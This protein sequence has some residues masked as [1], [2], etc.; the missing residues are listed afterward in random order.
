M[1]LGR[2]RERSLLEG[3]MSGARV[4]QSAV[5]VLTGEV[6]IGKSTLLEDAAA[7]ATGMRLLR[8]TGTESEAEVPFGA[9]LQLLRPALVQLDRIPAPQAEALATALALRPGTGSD[10]FAVGAGTLSLLSRFAEDQPLAVLVDDAHLLDQPSAQALVFAARRLTADPVVLLAAVRDGEPSPLLDAGLP[11]LAVGGLSPAASEDLVSASGRRLGSPVAARLYE[12]TGG[13]PLALLELADDAA[14]VDALPPGAPVPVPARVARAFARRADRLSAPARTA[15]LVA[16]AAGDDLA[17]IARACRL[18]DV[19]A[20]TLD[21]AET[22]QLLTVTAGRVGFRHNLVRSAV[23]SE[24]PPGVRR[25][26]HRALAAALPEDDVDH[27]AWHLGEAALGPDEDTARVLDAAA[28]RARDRSAHAVAATAFERAARLSPDPG[29]AV[30][31][32]VSAAESAWRAG[33]ADQAA[34]LLARASELPQPPALCVRAT[35]L[36]G[37][38]ASRTGSVERARDELMAAAAE[39]AGA[40]PDTAILLLA[41]AILACFFLADTATV[42]Q[43]AKRIDRL[44]DRAVGEPARW[45]GAVAGGVAGVLTGHGGPD[46]IRRAVRLLEP[47]APLLR[48]PRLAPWLVLGVLFL[49]ERGTG[50][51]IVAAVVDDLRRRSDLGGLPYLLFLVAR[52]QATGDRWDVA[53][54]NYTEG[55]QLARETGSTSD[56]AACLAGLAWLQARQG[57]E[58]ACRAHATEALDISGPRHLALFQVWSLSALGSLELGLGRPEAALAHLR[59]LD[60]LLADLRLVDVD[61]SPAPELAEALVHLGRAEDAR[62]QVARYAARA[63]EKGQPWALARAARTVALTCEDTDIDREFEQALEHHGRTLDPF[64]LARTQLAYGARL[65]RARRRVDAR[66][67]LRAALTAFDALGAGPWGDRAAVELRA[68]GGSAQRRQVSSVSDLTPQELQIAT[69]LAGGRTTREAAAALFLSPKTVE[70]HLRHVYLK[71][72]VSSRA[73][74]AVRLP[75]RG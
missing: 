6:G 65:R 14:V 44:V 48:D 70:Y 47:G 15:L 10:R 22:A 18:L 30:H 41:D 24:A 52:D 61:L 50:R 8:A 72:G 73:E 40:D 11:V 49:R 21:E 67:Q 28:G 2:E 17:L 35:G 4:G 5:L 19:D 53:E 71:L 43:A 33:L 1:L 57:R 25:A 60:A 62:A 38:I 54:V 3:L 34:A 46:R 75:A 55:A 64:E 69:M 63:A 51:E 42:A 29:D 7:S 12:A 66:V 20:A 26:V 59:R 32:L 31:R 36:G 39:G 9:L 56:L 16:A 58:D 23:W 45:V 68:T 74:L 27:R 37:T 13:N